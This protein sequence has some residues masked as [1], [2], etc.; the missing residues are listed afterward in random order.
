MHRLLALA[1]ASALGTLAPRPA[2]AADRADIGE[3]GLDDLLDLSVGAAALHEER[4]SEAAASVFVLTAEDLRLH[5]FRTLQEALASVPGL[6]AYRDDLYPSI[7]VRGV[8]LLTDYTTRLL[9][10]VDG[11][12]LNNSLGIGE[13]YLGRDLPIPLDAV[14]RIEVIQGPLGG[15]YGATAFLGVVNLVTHEPGLQG[16]W[17]RAGA[18]GA[19]GAVRGGEGGVAVAAESGPWRALAAADGFGTRG[20]SYV[21][22]ELAFEASGR[23]VPEGFRVSGA[24]GA[25]SGN[26][27][28]RLERAGLQATA[29]CG[30]ARSGTPTAPFSALLGGPA[31][32]V[33]NRTCFGQLAWSGRPADGWPA[34]MARL[35]LDDFRYWDRFAYDP[36]PVSTGTF[37][38]TGADRWLGGEGRATWESKAGMLVLGATVERHFT[39][40]WVGNEVDPVPIDVKKDFTSVNAY[41]IAER[42]LL[43]GLR[44][45]AAASYTWHEIFGA[46]LTPRLALV[47]R[48]SPSG[49]L[50]LVYAQGFRAPTAAEAFFRDGTD[51][52][53]NPDIRAE[54]VDA[55]EL[56][57]DRRLGPLQLQA[58]A[59][60]SRYRNLIRFTS[61]QVSGP[62][63]SL[64]PADY[65]Q[66]GQN[67]GAFWHG[68]AQLGVRLRWGRWLQGHGG[69][70]LQS[71]GAAGRV[72]FPFATATA[73]LATRALWEPLALSLRG[74]L[75]S[76]RDKDPAA[77]AQL[78]AGATSGRV[79]A[80]VLVG[81][82]AL[83]D[84]PWAP[85]LSV[86]LG[87]TNLLGA[88]APD[89][90]PGDSSPVTE[91]PQAPRTLRAALR[92]SSDRR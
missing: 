28:V 83:L 53:D 16:A 17:A 24:A 7:G 61:V 11:H 3:V 19:Q 4:A 43:P 59:F 77:V 39:D 63:G 20:P 64:D 54:V 22:P 46:R 69:V 57:W 15:V 33:E 44:A 27:F 29:A 91:L 23:P 58:S 6:F 36:P 14:R 30:E 25:A 31:N 89:P 60:G 35:S 78:P 55:V 67:Q 56:A 2:P 51:Y 68:G 82:G 41:A 80:A 49:L 71:I 48:Y 62:P 73:S 12:P 34:V 8:G 40:Q 47:W 52:L 32:R 87:V 1:V 18:E 21:Y 65:R 45:Q 92:W 66:V 81:A 9:V 50:K 42:H 76:P 38:D 84:L 37:R 86:E 79:G 72:N 88:R 70:S 13:S 10:L 5:G 26:L 75:A 74:T 90:L 85:G